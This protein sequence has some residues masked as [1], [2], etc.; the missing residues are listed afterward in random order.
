MEAWIG[1]VICSIFEKVSGGLKGRT[2][3]IEPGR[4]SVA[5]KAKK[6]ITMPV[7][8]SPQTSH[9]VPGCF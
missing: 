6:E 5:I 8:Q 9:I 1:Q 2:A 7:C 4:T 3:H